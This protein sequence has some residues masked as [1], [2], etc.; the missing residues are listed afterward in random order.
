MAEV[1][2]WSQVVE[3]KRAL[4]ISADG[5]ES[6]VWAALLAT[7]DW[8]VETVERRGQA[9]AR[10]PE[11]LPS[12]LLLDLQIGEVPENVEESFA[13][14]CR[15]S[16]L[17]AIVIL[18][19]PSPRDVAVS[20][21]RGAIDVLIPPFTPAELL[22]AVDRAGNFK[23]LYQEN[24]D[25]RRQLER[26][27]RELRESFNVL[28]MDQLA[29][30]QVQLDI[31]PR[32]PLRCRGYSVA[33]SI[34]PSLYLSGDFV[35]YNAVFDRYV[36]FYFGDVSGHGASS[37]F[38]TVM[39]AFLLRQLRRRHTV[40]KDFA[41]LARAP[42]GLAEHLNRQMLAMDL[43]K[44]LT[45]FS[46]AIDAETGRFR[47]VVSALSPPPI[48]VTKTAAGFLPGK[49]KPLGLFKDASWEIQ[50]RDFPPNSALVVVSDGLMER[51]DGTTNVA[52]ESRL[53]ELLTGVPPEHERICDA[54]GLNLI[55]EA[56]DDV[57]VLT[58]THN[59]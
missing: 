31:L 42:E 27:N 48:L 23:D 40:E 53:L 44:H 45:F 9:L 50:E 28:R 26:A 59:A 20:F 19:D 12:L 56:P 22:A 4:L 10:I 1:K 18:R 34:V 15:D 5:R 46:G 11:F 54:L 58:V 37:A 39:L 16:G 33:H 8:S 14:R 29:G 35:G 21:R 41:A 57:S 7:D 3:N 25:Y 52:R 43:D 55:K 24:M 38:V 30:R 36:L 17:A 47:Y 6:A 32:E 49:G 51:I 13:Q 2:A